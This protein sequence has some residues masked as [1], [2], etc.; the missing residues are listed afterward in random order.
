MRNTRTITRG[1]LKL[2]RHTPDY[3]SVCYQLPGE[4]QT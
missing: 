3:Q 1:G 2:R 4:S